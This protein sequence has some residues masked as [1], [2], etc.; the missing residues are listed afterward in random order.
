MLLC[1]W[2]K[3]KSIAFKHIRFQDA[4]IPQ[5]I[6]FPKVINYIKNNSDVNPQKDIE[7][8][9]LAFRFICVYESI[10]LPLLLDNMIIVAERYVESALLY[11][12]LNSKSQTHFLHII[13]KTIPEADLNIMIK[14]PS[15]VCYQRISM[16]GNMA[17]HENISKLEI[18]EKFYQ[19]L[20]YQ[21]IYFVNGVDEIKKV[22]QDIT[23]I[24]DMYLLKWSGTN[25]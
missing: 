25:E 24:V 15:H 19:N 3:E 9:Q 12:L 13:E 11:L 23:T 8:I 18:A 4:A 10:V 22:F 21:D 5:N 7:A 16:R 1:N 6:I 20:N 14:V 2:L 17:E